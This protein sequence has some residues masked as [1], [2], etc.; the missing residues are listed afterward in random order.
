MCELIFFLQ[1]TNGNVC[2]SLIMGMEFECLILNMQFPVLGFIVCVFKC[3]PI[4]ELFFFSSIF[5]FAVQ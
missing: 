1:V 5:L 4:S 2:Y 3:I